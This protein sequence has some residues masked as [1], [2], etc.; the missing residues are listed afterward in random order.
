MW[1]GSFHAG[2]GRQNGFAIGL[3]D[4]ARNCGLDVFL[5]FLGLADQVL[6]PGSELGIFLLLSDFLPHAAEI[7]KAARCLGAVREIRLHVARR[8]GIETCVS[9]APA[10]DHAVGRIGGASFFAFCRIY[11]RSLV[12]PSMR[13]RR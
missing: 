2:D 9:F 10:S 8:V 11:R 6:S 4:G 7:A 1:N 13:L 12:T 3:Q 5:Q